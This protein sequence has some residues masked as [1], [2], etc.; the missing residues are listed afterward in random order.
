LYAVEEVM[1][2]AIA[3]AIRDRERVGIGVNSPIPAAGVVLA[4]RSH[5]PRLRFR[6]PGLEGGV[7]FIGSKEFFDF[8]QRGELDV[9]FL[10][11]V[12]I[13]MSG[14]INL[15][16]LGDYER[17]RRRFP[18]AFGSAVLYPAVRRV[19]LFRTEHT[20]R[21]FV[22]R[23]DFVTAAGSPDRVV[24]SRAVLGFDKPAGRLVLHS[25]HP[26]QSVESVR[27]ATGF[28]L[29]SPAGVGETPA[30]TA[31]ELRVLRDDVYPLLAGVYPRFV[32]HMRSAAATN[33]AAP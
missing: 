27:A 18:G 12:Q 14:R 22:P 4:Q 19:I 3:R 23:V 1:A 8:A 9:F 33:S 15:H 16:V 29:P 6:L 28:E 24:T 7:P 2:C 17:P 10:S 31:D 32:E 5:A 20:P 21:V 30:P 25:Y 13:D 11:G 26:G